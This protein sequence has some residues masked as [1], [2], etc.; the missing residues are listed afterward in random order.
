MQYEKWM[1]VKISRQ[2]TPKTNE[3]TAQSDRES[4]VTPAKM[5]PLEKS[6]V[7]ELE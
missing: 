6:S 5:L 2:H 4:S 1:T 7:L 3:K